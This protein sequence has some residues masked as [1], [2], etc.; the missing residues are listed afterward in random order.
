MSIHK[1]LSLGSGI[2]T[3]RSVFSR[4]ERVDRLIKEGKL[5]PEDSPIGL[6]K[7]RTQ[8]K[9]VSRKAKKAKDADSKLG[10]G[11]TP[12]AAE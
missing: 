3:E 12:E 6:P 1:S 8:F 10:E 11:E 7:V 4:R 9:V 5:S 2:S